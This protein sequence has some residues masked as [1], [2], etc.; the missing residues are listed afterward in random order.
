MKGAAMTV[1]ALL[2]IGGAMTQEFGEYGDPFEIVP[3]TLVEEMHE[4][5]DVPIT[6]ECFERVC[7]GSSCRLSKMPC[8]NQPAEAPWAVFVDDSTKKQRLLHPQHAPGLVDVKQHKK[9]LCV[10]CAIAMPGIP[11]EAP[12]ALRDAMAK[13]DKLL[14]K[15]VKLEKQE[16]KNNPSNQ[17]AQWLTLYKSIQHMPPGPDKFKNENL[18][19]KLAKQLADKEENERANGGNSED[20]EEDTADQPASE[21]AESSQD[22]SAVPLPVKKAMLKKLVKAIIEKHNAQVAASDDG[23]TTNKHMS[24]ESK[25]EAAKQVLPFLK[26]LMGNMGVLPNQHQ[27]DK[28]TDTINGIPVGHQKCFER[29]CISRDTQGHCAAA[30][31][32]CGVN[33]KKPAHTGELSKEDALKKVKG[34]MSKILPLAGVPGLDGSKG[35]EALLELLD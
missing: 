21:D 24:A 23:K 18:L 31:I 17:R 14:A 8:R 20:T 7:Q 25:E 19:L 13:Q 34:S 29:A 28:H 27:E 33:G 9:P 1:F 10:N 11:E 2:I 15:I 22:S 32:S 4:P 26:K 35:L 5:A 3:E 16:M 6:R 30:V 12:K